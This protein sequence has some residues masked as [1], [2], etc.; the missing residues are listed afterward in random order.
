M[1]LTDRWKR[2]RRD[3]RH[4]RWLGAARAG[5]THAFVKLYREV[6]DPVAD[7]L[8]VR[9]PTP[10]DAEDLI[11]TVFQRFLQNLAKYDARRGSVVA[12]LVTMARHALIDHLRRLRPSLPVEELAEVLAGRAPDPLEQC[13][14]TEQADRVRRAL[15]RQPDP[16]REMFA[17][18]YGQGLRY[19]E[20]GV[21]MGMS[22]AAV[23]QR[24]SRVCRELRARLQENES[25]DRAAVGGAPAAARA[26]EGEV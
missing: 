12:W 20:I 1:D 21:L 2:R 15:A 10:E 14:R 4:A 26:T 3:R 24:F 19:R 9:A 18:H 7:Y 17:L 8:A 22:E 16:V 11:A 25:P 5:D 13:I 6:Y 23:K